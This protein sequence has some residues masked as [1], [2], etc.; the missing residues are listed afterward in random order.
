MSHILHRKIDAVMPIAVK[1][2]GL[3]VVDSAGKRYL[4]ASGGPSVACLGHSDADVQRAVAEQV[5][6]IAYVSNQFFTTPAAEELADILIAGAPKG[7]TRV[8][9]C[10]GGSEAVE[11]ALKM[12]RQYFL[13]IGQPE[14]TKFIA[15]RQSYHGTTIGALSLGGHMAR[16]E[17]YEPLLM[18]ETAHISPCYAYRGRRDDE[19]EESYG[20]RVAD[21]LETTIQT[22]GP[23]RVAAFFAETVVGAALGA[24][25]AV[26]GYF[27]R[28]REICDRYGV[29][30]VLD[31]VMSGMGRTGTLHACEQEGIVPDIMT[32]AKGLG[33]GYQPIGAVMIAGKVV[34]AFRRGSG[35]FQHGLTYMAHPVACAAALAVQKAIRD[36]DLLANVRA[37]GKT[38]ERLLVERFGNHRHVGDIRGRGLFW[39]LEFV[40]DRASKEPFDA[41]LALYARI[42]AEGMAQ[43]LIVYPSGGNVDGVKGDTVIVSPPFTVTDAQVREIVDR[44]GD[45]VDKALAGVAR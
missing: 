18:K 41:K 31:E 6:G 23:S 34:D 21:E 29:L 14:R 13:E 26:A 37:R 11:T 27:K 7:M 4:D 44:L 17:P 2:D 3:Y 45:V 43:G 36:R 24:V 33:A 30:L 10:Q 32:F 40:A 15:R 39:G 25:P 19:T 28:V 16:R 9:Y 8:T 12:A 20:R 42:K 35:S 5:S 22:L 38:L 1:G